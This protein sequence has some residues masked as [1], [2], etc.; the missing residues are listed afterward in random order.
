MRLDDVLEAL[1]NDGVMERYD[2]EI[3]LADVVGTVA[4]THDFD[5]DF[6][7]R[8]RDDRWRRTEE[9]FRSGSHPPPIDVV[10]LGDN[11]LFVSDGHH[12]ISVARS[13][14]WDTL[15]ARVH[16]ICTVAFALCCLRV[17]HLPAK[18]AERRFLQKV[19]LPD[20]VSRGLWLDRPADWARLADAALAWGYTHHDVIGGHS[21]HDL[22]TAWWRHEVQPVVETMRREGAGATLSDVQLFVTAL[23]ARDRLGALDW[24]GELLAAHEDASCC[25]AE[26]DL[27]VDDAE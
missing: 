9:L 12:R 16:R 4:R 5:A 10:R 26:I 21:A 2:D 24:P 11:L 27:L 14:G 20:E 8:R 3:A 15:P 19:P 18:A 7:P 17:S 1:G 23:A 13:L 6:S 22:G 25:H